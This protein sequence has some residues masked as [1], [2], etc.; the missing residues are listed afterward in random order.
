MITRLRVWADSHTSEGRWSPVAI[1]FHWTMAALVLFQLVWGWWTSGI[2]VGGDK[3][4]AY[5][6]HADVGLL[7]LLLAVLPYQ[8]KQVA[9]AGPTKAT[10]GETLSFELALETA[11]GRAGRHVLRLEVFAPDGA[12]QPALGANIEAVDGAATHALPLALNS[13]AGTWKITA[14]DVASGATGKALFEVIPSP[15]SA[16]GP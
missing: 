6:L 2:P 7:I 8:L 4:A 9:I 11:A 16:L 10:A 5:Q 15:D 13:A 3:V 14:R 12:A 1:T